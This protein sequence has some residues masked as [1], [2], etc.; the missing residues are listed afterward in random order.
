MHEIVTT[1]GGTLINIQAS[2]CVYSDIAYHSPQ[3]STTIIIM[4]SD[5]TQISYIDGGCISYVHLR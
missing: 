5:I 2:I 3:G 1:G 4:L